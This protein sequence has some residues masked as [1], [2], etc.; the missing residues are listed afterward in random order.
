MVGWEKSLSVQRAATQ[1]QPTY[2]CIRCGH[3]LLLGIVGRFM[4]VGGLARA[5]AHCRRASLAVL[6]GLMLL[7]GAGCSTGPMWVGAISGNG[8]SPT[9]GSPGAAG[10]GGTTA[11]GGGHGGKTGGSTPGSTGGSGTDPGASPVHSWL[12]RE[13]S[14]RP[15]AGRHRDLRVSALQTWSASHGCRGPGVRRLIHRFLPSDPAAPVTVLDL[16]PHNPCQGT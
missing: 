7:A 4:H 1:A 15:A 8:V 3:A 16:I 10:P 14:A 11:P 9:P 13:H 5:R 12:D 6:A 2:W